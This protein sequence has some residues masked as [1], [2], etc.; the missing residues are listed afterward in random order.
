MNTELMQNVSK[1]I[2]ETCMGVKSGEKVLIIY[3]DPNLPYADF[4]SDE[5]KKLGANVEKIE[6]KSEEMEIESPKHVVKKMLESN[7]ILFVLSPRLIQLVAHTNARNKATSKGT[8][9]GFIVDVMVNFTKEDILKINDLTLKMSDILA[10]GEIAK[11]TTRKG[12]NLTMRL[13]TDKIKRKPVALKV[14][15]DKP[16]DWGVIPAYAEAAIAPIEGTAE[17]IAVID[18]FMEKVGPIENPMRFIIKNGRLVDVKGK[19]EA[20]KLKKLIQEAD[21]NATNIAELG[22]GTSH[23]L[24]EPM[25][26]LADKMIIGTVHIAIG[27]NINIG[28]NTFSKIHHD[29][30]ILDAT[31]EIDGK[32]IL[33]NGKLTI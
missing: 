24:K 16:G 23:M 17:G 26:F 9:V 32:I 27:K 3:T 28:G 1:T 31:L 5:A 12:T 18:D 33:D 20:E 14:L 10:N 2:V 30:I 22:I 6:V 29:A 13:R 15:L 4:L 19:E 21:E 8:R 7:V 25:K 11:V